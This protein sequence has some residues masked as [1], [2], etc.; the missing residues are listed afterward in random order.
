MRQRM[1][2]RLRDEL[3]VTDDEMKALQPKIEQVM[4]LE[5]DTRG[6]GFFGGRGGRGGP[7]G[8]GGNNPG[9]QQSDVQTKQAELQA[10]LDNKDSKPEDIKAKLDAFRAAKAKA[11]DDLTKAQGDLKSLLT[12]RQEAVLVLR[13]ML[14]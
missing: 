9:G 5:R 7:G 12:Q 11:K 10:V 2:D 14:D 8:G 4:T 1:M 6:G 3:G 13:G